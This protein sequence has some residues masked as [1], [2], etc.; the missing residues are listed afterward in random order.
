MSNVEQLM[1]VDDVLKTLGISRSKLHDLVRAGDLPA[2]KFG[3]RTMFRPGSV[4]KFIESHET[5]VEPAKA[6]VRG[7]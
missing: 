4:Q 5:R 7:L 2:V 6:K 3:R 1:N